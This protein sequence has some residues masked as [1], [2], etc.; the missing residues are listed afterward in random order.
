MPNKNREIGK[1]YTFITIKT[2]ESEGLFVRY[3]YL[4]WYVHLYSTSVLLS[5]QEF[6]RP[7]H[8]VMFKVIV[9]I[10]NYEVSQGLIK[11]DVQQMPFCPLIYY[12]CR[13]YMLELQNGNWQ[14]ARVQIPLKHFFAFVW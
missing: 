1:T 14:L 12:T 13:C 9:V 6:M 10:W 4:I 11:E 7:A 8:L 5:I 2:V 3:R